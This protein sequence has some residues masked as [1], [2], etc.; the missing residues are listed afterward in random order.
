MRRL[1]TAALITLTLAACGGGDPNAELPPAEQPV[2]GEPKTGTP[3]D[4]SACDPNTI[5]PATGLPR[6]CPPKLA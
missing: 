1:I 4:P 6:G 2:A 3:P 5:D